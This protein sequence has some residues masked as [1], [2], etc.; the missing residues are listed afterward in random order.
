M[1]KPLLLEV[2][3]ETVL[4]V[5]PEWKGKPITEDEAKRLL[6]HISEDT[7]DWFYGNIETVVERHVEKVIN[8]V[9]N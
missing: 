8:E 6:S 9:L 5:I 3:F 4:A 1:S 2:D 7:R